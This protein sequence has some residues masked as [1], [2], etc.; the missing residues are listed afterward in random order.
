MRGSGQGR[1]RVTTVLSLGVG[2]AA[3]TPTV[4]LF[5]YRQPEPEA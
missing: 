3:L 2:R 1:D 5:A 4:F